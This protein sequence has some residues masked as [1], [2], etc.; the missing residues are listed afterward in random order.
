MKLKRDDRKYA[1]S[2]YQI[3]VATFPTHSMAFDQWIT[4]PE[5]P[6]L[7]R[8]LTNLSTDH[9][10][11]LIEWHLKAYEIAEQ[12][13]RQDRVKF[14]KLRQI[15]SQS[16]FR[17]HYIDFSKWLDSPHRPIDSNI[18]LTSDEESRMYTIADIRPFDEIFQHSD[19][20][21]PIY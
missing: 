16:L 21:Y 5:T 13:A 18:Q 19:S 6:K 20:S 12:A 11:D 1:I 15:W 10:I 8:K 4:L 7:P 9:T 14:H 3:W 17:S 2:I